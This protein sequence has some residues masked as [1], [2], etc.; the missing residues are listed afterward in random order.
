MK[1]IKPV[2]I[3]GASGFIAA[4]I[5]REL[6]EQGYRVRGTVRKTPANYPFLLSLPGA[7]ERLELVQADLLAAGTYDRA[8]EGCDY[9]MHTA[10]P[11]E[12]N[13]KNPQ[14]DLVD[15]AVNGFAYQF[16][17]KVYRGN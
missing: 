12:I 13:V 17:D 8:V 9:V 16:S 1:T 4:H 11:Y 2:C 10:S 7:A 15:P 6:L 3:T 14:T 5:V